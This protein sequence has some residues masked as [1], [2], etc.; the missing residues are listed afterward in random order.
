MNGRFAQTADDVKGA[1]AGVRRRQGL[2]QRQSADG[3]NLD[4]VARISVGEK[5]AMGLAWCQLLAYIIAAP[6]N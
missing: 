4:A 3:H 2:C 1:I 6:V 5:V